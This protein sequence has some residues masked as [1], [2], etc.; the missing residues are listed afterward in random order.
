MLTLTCIVVL[1]AGCQSI[2]PDK[3]CK[4]NYN[5][6][7]T[8]GSV[9]LLDGDQ[10][11]WQLNYKK[12]E[13]RPYFHPLGLT[14]G[15]ELTA[16]RPADHVWH[17]A[18]WFSWKQINGVNYW[19]PEL[20]KG[21]T[22]IIEVK[23]K[24]GKDNQGQVEMYLSYHPIGEAEIL[25]EKR[26]LTISSP[27]KKGS[28]YIDWTSIFTAAQN[29]VVFDRTA[30]PGEKGGVLHGGY[31]GLSLRMAKN[32]K[33]WRFTSSK[34]QLKQFEHEKYKGRFEVRGDKASWV[35]FSGPIKD[36]K[37]AGIAVFDH[38]KNLNHPS[39]WW[40]TSDMPYFSPAVIY[41]KALTLPGGESFKLQYRVWVHAGMV[42]KNVLDKQWKSFVKKS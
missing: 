17:R 29:D 36:D 4:S 32:T 1:L 14:D 40:I 8:D 25:K 11:V 42:D 6:Q 21:Q 7:R 2:Q 3:V 16:L 38:P 19:D 22:E 39:P 12:A 23:T 5:W 33:S 20:P 35:D 28:Y 37:F 41:H 26:F 18:L 31:A 15:T 10:V 13:G 30:I 34:G 24:L 9:A 27:D